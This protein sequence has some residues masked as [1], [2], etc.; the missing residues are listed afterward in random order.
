MRKIALLFVMAISLVACKTSNSG[1]MTSK[2]K[3]TNIANK[4]IKGEW[5]LQ[6]ITYSQ[7]GKFNVTLLNDTSKECFE[8]STWK[9]WRYGMV[10]IC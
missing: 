9:L 6:S 4:A 8:G 10:K 1:T 2:P 3:E 5:T 7:S